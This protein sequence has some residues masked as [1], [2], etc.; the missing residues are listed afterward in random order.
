MRWSKSFFAKTFIFM[1]IVSIG[2]VL[3]TNFVF[4]FSAKDKLVYGIQREAIALSNE[5]AMILRPQA[6]SYKKLLTGALLPKQAEEIVES[7]LRTMQ[8]TFGPKGAENIYTLGLYRE[9]IYVIGD[10]DPTGGLPLSL[11]DTANIDVKLK[12][13]FSGIAATTAPYADIYGNWI[14]GYAPIKDVQGVVVA[15]VG[16]DMPVGAFGLIEEII[17]QDILISF[18]P[19]ILFAAGMSYW[20]SRLVT[21]PVSNLTSGLT[22]IARG[23][24]DVKMQETA[25]DEFGQVSRAFNTLAEGL[26][27]KDR[28]GRFLKQA[29]SQ[30]IA[31]ALLQGQIRQEGELKEATVL[32]ADI[33]GFTALSETLPARDV[34]ALVNA[35]LSVLVPE[36]SRYGG[37]VDKFVGDEI[38]ALFGIPESLDN[39][40]ESAV[41]AAIAMQ[42]A[43]V[44]LNRERNNAR[45]PTAEIGIGINTGALIA[46]NVGTAERGNY[47]ALGSTVNVGARLCSVAHAGQI[48]INQ[49]TYLRCA[50]A[51][52]M[53]PLELISVKGVSFPLTIFLVT[54]NA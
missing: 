30:E 26:R 7:P 32:F 43:V 53:T 27:E 47:T 38:F 46:G 28:I 48:I 44:R 17:Q 52:D 45:L 23:E 25:Q 1:N 54:G 31:S 42:T 10:P 4:Y 22:K 21:R 37:V 12:V 35:Y 49:N 19:A 51:F 18:I 33:R 40:A 2:V 8:L 3:I 11:E 5:A 41:K 50:T 9:R 20:V 34:I 14:S 15:I 36:I 13:L 16:I 24:L 6:D 39:D 29:I